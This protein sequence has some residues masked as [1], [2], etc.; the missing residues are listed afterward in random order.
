MP[1]PILGERICAVLVTRES[2]PLTVAELSGFLTGQRITKMRH[3]EH[4]VI[5]EEM[6]MTPTR[7]IIKKKLVNLVFPPA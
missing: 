6:P 3:P 4:I 1:D 5:V 7:K 2:R